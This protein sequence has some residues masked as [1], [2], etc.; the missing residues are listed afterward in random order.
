MKMEVKL[1]TIK[2]L[3]LELIYIQLETRWIVTLKKNV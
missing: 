1:R 2:F 3:G